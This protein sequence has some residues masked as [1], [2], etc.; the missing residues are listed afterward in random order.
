MKQKKIS[1]WLK[2]LDIVL[3]LMVLTFFVGATFGCLVSGIIGLD[4][5]FGAAVGMV[6]MFC[7]MLNCPIASIILSVEI[8]G[9]QGLLFFAIAAAISYMLSGY[10][11]LYHSQRI[12]YSKTK[13]EY[14]DKNI[15]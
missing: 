4:P 2:G 10:H 9:S 13:A 6:A 5:G 7:G 15:K 3:A 11:G 14:I 8:F 1:Y 12:V